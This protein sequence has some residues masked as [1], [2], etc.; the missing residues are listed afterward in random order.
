MEEPLI[1]I[2]IPCWKV[3][4]WIV[5][6]LTSIYNQTYNNYEVV[7]IIDN[8][9]DSTKDIVKRFKKEN[10]RD[11]KLRIFENK[12]NLGSSKTRQI[13]IDNAVGDYIYFLDA[14]DWIEKDSLYQLVKIIKQ[15]PQVDVVSGAFRDIYIDYIKDYQ[16]NIDLLNSLK[17]CQITYLML[18]RDVRWNI[19]NRLISKKLFNIV[20]FPENNNGEDY[21]LMSKI[22][23]NSNHVIFTNEITYNYN[24]TNENTFQNTSNL[25][26]NILDMSRAFSQLS[27]YFK[28]DKYAIQAIE[29]G[30]IKYI[31]QILR[32]ITKLS[33]FDKIYVPRKLYHCIKDNKLGLKYRLIL[34]LH[35][36]GFKRSLCTIN[37]ILNRL[38]K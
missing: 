25:K 34:L 10:D 21:V 24:H 2:I 12:N 38:K 6:C 1:S 30:H 27:L 13:G 14:D 29:W 36:L 33:N 23:Y 16:E 31:V 22:L 5:K 32:N 9:P 18:S 3:E 7:I 20:S 15:T 11:N 8:S 26:K 17:P 28:N 19:W 37:T 35:F 4:N